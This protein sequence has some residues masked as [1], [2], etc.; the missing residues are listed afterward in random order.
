MKIP[1]FEELD[2]YQLAFELQQEIFESSKSFP[3]DET[4][5]LTDQVRRSSRSVGANIAEAW[6]KRQYPAHFV[7]KLTD[8][9][10]ENAE[11]QH[12][13]RTVQ[14]SGYLTTTRVEELIT[15]SRL[16]GSKLGRMMANADQWKPK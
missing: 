8:S 10:G 14:A 5:S 15:K 2:V 16:I 13:L 9:D 11:T 1:S 3:K 12:W 4:Y 7:S 6:R